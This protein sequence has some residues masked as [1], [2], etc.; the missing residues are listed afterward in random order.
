[1]TTITRVDDETADGGD[2]IF[3]RDVE[4]AEQQGPEQRAQ[5]PVRAAD[6]DDDEERDQKLDR[7]GRIDAADDVRGERAAQSR[8]AAAD[9]EGDSKNAVDIDPEAVGDAGVID[10]RPQLRAE[11]GLDEKDLQE[12]G[13]RRRKRRR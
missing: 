4:H 12:R 8:K 3:A 11:A 10:R 6:G 13:D 5:N 7:E 2:I 9:G 1:M